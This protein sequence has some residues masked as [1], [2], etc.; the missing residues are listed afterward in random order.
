RDPGRRLG[1]DA[2][3][4]PADQRRAASDPAG[5]ARSRAGRWGQLL[6]NGT[7]CGPAAPEA[8]HPSCAAA[9]LDGPAAHLRP[10]L[11]PY[12]G[13]PRL[14]HRNRELVHLPHRV[15]LFELRVRRG[16][17]VLWTAGHHARRSRAH[18]P[19]EDMRAL[20]RYLAAIV[21]LVFALAPV[22]W[23]ITIS[24]KVEV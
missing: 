17:V 24:L 11:Y 21:A 13:R 3:L 4:V 6:A 18:A 2:L 23:L 10:D 22:Y 5:A 16:D 7:R 1:M 20:A 15:S 14:G 8:D 12:A 9:A 19:G